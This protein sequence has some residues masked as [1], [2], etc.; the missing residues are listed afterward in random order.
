MIPMALML[1]F[2]S[3]PPV[4]LAAVRLEAEN[5]RP[6][7]RAV[8]SAPVAA[9]VEQDGRNL[10]LVLPAVHPAAGLELPGPVAEIEALSIEDRAD[11]VRLRI[12]LESALPY[13]LRQDGVVVSVVIRA[14]APAMPAPAPSA[15]PSARP[16]SVRDLYARILPPPDAGAAAPAD[17][18][19][20]QGV[21]TPTPTEETDVLRFGF[22]RLRPWV[23]LSY[24]D[25][26]TAFLDT[27]APVRDRYFEIDPH[28]G[29]SAGGR[30]P[31][32]GRF[33]LTYEPRF[34]FSSRYP[35]LRTPTHLATGSLDV[36]VGAFVNVHAS[37]HFAKGLLETTE[38]DQGREYFF[39]L[40]PFERNAAQVGATVNPGG[41]VD[42]D[43][44]AIRDDIDIEEEGGFFSHRVD[45]IWSRLNYHFG[46]SARAFLRYEYDRVPPPDE[47]PVVESRA[48]TLSVGVIGELRPLLQADLAVGFTDLSAPQAG[49]GGTQFRGTTLSASLRK[50]FSPGTSIS[51]LGRRDTYPS[52]FEDNAFYIAT[53]AGVEADLGLPFSVVFHGAAGWQRNDYR[54]AAAG[55]SE[56]RKD[57]LFSWSLGAG[58]GLTRWSFVRVDYRYDRR[59][60]NL[61]AY[62]TDGHLFMLQLGIGYLSNP[63]GTV[64]R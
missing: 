29:L 42:L 17:A 48:S 25:V 8:V 46:V 18:T 10:F 38:V 13:S 11:G 6:V 58:R 31:G 60:S 22:F 47:R 54:V 52:G 37:Y 21:P 23:G 63:T 19:P 14:P 2:L 53:G 59:E 1:S 40:V 57:R 32:N 61:P 12:R 9:R 3:D 5:D 45:T 20:D 56:P 4:T 34:R 43:V 36:P 62:E 28:L 44:R 33:D 15:S 55:L 27:P 26:K 64:P 39:Q 30:L 51:L 49:T 41:I 24:V 50:E 7:V 35:E 16:D